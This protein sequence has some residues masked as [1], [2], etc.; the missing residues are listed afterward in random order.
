MAK[1]AKRFYDPEPRP[2]CL[3]CGENNANKLVPISIISSHKK[4]EWGADYCRE[5][6]AKLIV[7][8]SSGTPFPKKEEG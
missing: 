3:S 6:L 2:C 8:A 4:H 7:V 5:C 1:N